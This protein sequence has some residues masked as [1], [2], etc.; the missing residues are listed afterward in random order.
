[1]TGS[2][3]IVVL[4]AGYAGLS[5]ARRL[6]RRAHGARITVVD[7][8]SE[9]VERVRL[10]Q[11][12]AGQRI[13]RWGL[14]ELLARKGIEFVQGRAVELD[15]AA[16][17]IALADG[18][19]VGYDTLVYALGS[20]ADVESVAGVRL[21]AHTVATP[22]DVARVGTLHGRVTVVGGGST[23]IETATELAA[24]RPDLTVSLLSAAEPGAWLSDRARRHI[25]AVLDR[26]GVEVRSD[27][28][29]VE[30]LPGGLRLA[31]GSEVPAETVLWTTGFEVPDLAARAGL[32]V[33]ARG[34]LLVDEALRTSDPAVYAAGDCAAIAGPDGRELRMACATALPSGA[35]AAIAVLARLQ[36]AQ[37]PALRFRY[38]VQCISLGRRD[39]VI[40]FVRPDDTPTGRVLTGRP[41]AWFKEAV[42]R[43]A[44][45]SVRP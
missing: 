11:L 36:D 17:R 1:M 35:H 15:P 9:L 20:A 4:G 10:H 37:P 34:R 2:H 40:Q 41:A 44:G 42:V 8:R 39:A 25:R 12:A 28:K 45:W 7:A 27:A 19:L 18:A 23:G 26:L 14:R 21:H 16:K 43:G 32:A 30:V 33:D 31:D 29:V 6:A 5:A 38:Q 22:E 13:P 3:R 24:A